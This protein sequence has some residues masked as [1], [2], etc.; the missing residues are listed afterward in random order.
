MAKRNRSNKVNA[1]VAQPE[2]AAPAV[3]AQATTLVV[4]ITEKQA[5]LGGTRKLC[6]ELAQAFAG[7]PAADFMAAIAADPKLLPPKGSAKGRVAWLARQGYI[8]L[9]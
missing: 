1:P 7:K 5:K 2:I 8:T 4:N 9:S 6:Y 3:T